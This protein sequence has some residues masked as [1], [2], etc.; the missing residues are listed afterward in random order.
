[1]AA[2]QELVPRRLVE[3]RRLD[4]TGPLV[5]VIDV[6]LVNDEL[7][8]A[9]FRVD[10]L[11][12]AAAQH[13]FFEARVSHSGKQK[14]LNLSSSR[15]FAGQGG[16][17]VVEVPVPADILERRSRWE[18]EEYS[19]D[20]AM[21]FV[22]D[23]HPNDLVVL[24]DIDEIPSLGQ[25]EAA[26]SAACSSP[27]LS[28]PLVVSYRHANLVSSEKWDYARAFLGRNA[29]PGIRFRTGRK[30][31]G[32]RGSHLRYVRYG[33]AAVT[34][35]HADFAH[36][37]LDRKE[38]GDP[39]LLRVCDEYMLS[40]LPRFGKGDVGLLRSLPIRGLGP[41]AQAYVRAFPEAVHEGPQHHPWAQRVTVSHLL[42]RRLLSSHPQPILD[43]D[44]LLMA[45]QPHQVVYAIGALILQ[46]SRIPTMAR[47]FQRLI[48]FFL[49]PRR[50]G[51]TLGQAL[52]GV[53]RY[54]D[55]RQ[56]EIFH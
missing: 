55:F 54:G 41:V 38:F 19:R 21:W 43:P 17:E 26:K 51:R 48:S 36:D 1:M 15:L 53:Y 34:R 5:N 9:Q 32:E 39:G 20:W 12:G 6:V 56:R 4:E 27:V 44:Q 14:N 29:V 11:R 24:C 50:K 13:Y 33:P 8:L 23:R 49:R 47:V 52:R 2:P 16:V 22:A 31:A 37:E 3:A 10:Y 7:E 25:I 35:K 18:I 40:H 45:R 30:V 28:I 42:S 46:K